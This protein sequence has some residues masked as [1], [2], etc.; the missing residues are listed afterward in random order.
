[1]PR[2]TPYAKERTTNDLILAVDLGGTKLAAGL[3]D[4]TPAVVM[5]SVVPAVTDTQDACL[6]SLFAQIDA[7]LAQ[8]PRPVAA[9]GVGVASIIDFARGALV[10]ST[11]L[12]LSDVPL[13]ELLRQRYALPVAIDNDATVACIGEHQ[14]GAGAGTHEMLMLTLGTGI[15]GGIII[16]GKPYRG[17][18]GAAAE[19]GHVVVDVNGPPC[20]G[21]CPN[22]GCLESVCSGTAIGKAAL[23]AARENPRSALGR[24]LAADETIDG[25][26]ASKL[27]SEGDE[28]ARAVLEKIGTLLGVGITG[29]VNIFN[30]ELVVVGGGA[31]QAGD[32]LLEPARAVVRTRGLRPQRDQA[33]IV[34]AR[35]GEEAGLVGA[36]ALAL[37]EL[38][39]RA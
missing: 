27:A 34:A 24:A 15:G 37:T 4:T 3:V 38:L 5:R 25:R 22:H 23:L 32:L 16:G 30:P 8:A 1:L 28:I 31:A 36:A 17:L 20:Q 39:E 29:L 10:M 2:V 9:I 13:R 19:L 33:R 7:M 26:L 18:S 11:N 6:A 35:F 21:N 12:P 14:W